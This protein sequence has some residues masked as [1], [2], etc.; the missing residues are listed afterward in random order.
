MGRIRRGGYLSMVKTYA[1]FLDDL[2]RKITSARHQAARTVN[3]ELI[4]LYW[5]I[6]KS[7]LEKQESE[8]WG[9]KIIE[10]LAKDLKQHFP[11]MRGF[12]QRNLKYMRNFAKTWPD[13][14]IVQQLAAQLP[15]WHNVI[16]M[17]KISNN[18]DRLWYARKAI[19]NGWSR[20]VLTTQIESDLKVRLFRDDK[21]HNFSTTLPSPQ[22][23]LAHDALKDPYIFDFLSIGQEA[24]EREIENALVDH[25]QKFLLELGAGFAYVGRQF[26]LS[27]A[28]S[29]YYLDLLFYHTKLHCYVVIELKAGDFKPEY[30]GKLNFYLSAMDDL[31]KGP[32]DRPTIGILLCKTKEK[33][34][35]EYA[36]KDFS[37]P[38]GISEYKFGDVIPEKI[39]TALP[40]I[41]ELEEAMGKPEMK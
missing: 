14:Q 23:D 33:I 16:L 10:N 4:L 31:V 11:E 15:W 8:G 21:T 5:D 20:N 39:K 17:D 35:A 40:S 29:D 24:Q 36:L 9:S 38:M 41:E 26:H 6:G 34:I 27:V 30:V 22:S 32:E 13:H 3:Q 12:S 18:S 37:K 25:I 7:I 28:N 1:E 2:K 19:E